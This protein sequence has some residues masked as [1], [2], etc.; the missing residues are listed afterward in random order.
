[1]QI[2]LK[3]AVSRSFTVVEGY[4]V[5][6]LADNRVSETRD[7]LKGSLAA[8]ALLVGALAKGI[9]L[10]LG[11]LVRSPAVLVEWLDTAADV[12]L[13]VAACVLGYRVWRVL[14]ERL[15]W[16]VRRKLTLSYVFIGFIPVLLVILFFL[17]SGILLFFNVGSYLMRTR[18]EALVE[19]VA[20]MADT[21]TL[22]LQRAQTQG[23][24]EDALARRQ[25]DA[26][27]MYPN[28][29]YAV[30][31]VEKMCDP[32]APPATGRVVPARVVAGPWAHIDAPTTLPAWVPCDGR[33]GLLAY[34]EGPGGRTRLAV[35]AIALPATLAPAFAV[36]VDLPLG[37]Q[38]SE[39]LRAETGIRLGDMTAIGENDT[40]P[41][42]QAMRG[43][44]TPEV[45]RAFE[46]PA[47]PP[48]SPT[49]IAMGPASITL[50]QDSGSSELVWVTL[51]D[52]TDW[53]TGGAGALAVSFQMSPL[54]TYERISTTSLARIGN[55]DFGQILLILLAVVGGLFLVIQIVAFGM[56][57]ALA[58]SI[59]GAVHEL[60]VGTER[61]RRGDF[62]HKIQVRSRDQ[63]G[64]LASSFN[65]MTASIEDLLRQK[66]EKERLEQELRVARDIQMSLLPQGELRM[67]GLQLGGYCRPAREVG[68][69]YYDLLPL[70]EH[71][72]GILIADVAGKGTS[73]ALY[74]AELK[75]VA[76]SLSRQH[77]SPRQLLIEANRTLSPHL[78]SR[79][80][81]TITYALVDLEARTLTYA[82]AGHCPL[83]YL[84]GPAAAAAGGVQVLAPSGMVLGLKLD[85]GRA[86]SRLLEEVTIPLG[87][88][89]L[90]VLFTDGITE[91]MNP[92]GDCFGDERLAALIEQHGQ[93]AVERLRERILSEVEAF[94]GA[95]PQQDDMTMLFLRVE[96]VAV[97][98]A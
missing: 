68:G 93:M 76:W 32:E 23:E 41:G 4:S 74:M 10:T 20:F 43:G 27:S 16:R 18:V 84:P 92:T 85:D 83:M 95:A 69:D 54:D 49:G 59:T 70:D 82:R 81:I 89:D 96:G 79:S 8:R 17:V 55:L 21:T 90:F 61:V 38:L 42:G 73:A 47:R 52:F 64:E 9:T 86:F 36:V 48:Q 35:R 75:G 33:E 14:K 28:V 3:R 34:T 67:R 13:V 44:A 91:A 58:R 11:A 72:L 37:D 98:A 1:M 30:V 2:V 51:L 26:S 22:A 87:P 97:A 25:S 63:L 65:S 31:P 56:G 50:G 45:G 29:S 78:D 77:R 57:F 19:Q 94:V 62:T 12:C 40:S 80:F 60:F 71:R 5:I 53:A 24:V 7:W 15:L 88:G 66:A 6:I 39:R 46:G